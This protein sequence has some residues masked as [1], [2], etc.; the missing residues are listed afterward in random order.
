MVTANKTQW[1]GAEEGKG[2]IGWGT[3]TTLNESEI[4]FVLEHTPSPRYSDFISA[5]LACALG[6]HED[7]EE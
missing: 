4:E 1:K 2:G 3:N 6:C 5:I 7:F